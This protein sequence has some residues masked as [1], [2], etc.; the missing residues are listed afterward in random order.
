M[1]F[2]DIH[3]FQRSDDE[4]VETILAVLVAPDVEGLP[5]DG[6][7]SVAVHPK[8]VTE[9]VEE[10]LLFTRDLVH[11]KSVVAVGPT[12]VD[13][14]VPVAWSDQLR[15]FEDQLSIS[16]LLCKPLIIHCVRGHSDVITLH[17]DLSPIQPWVMHGF[18]KGGDTLNRVIDAELY[19][20][21]GASIMQEGS[22][23]SEAIKKVPIA[24][25][26]LETGEQTEHSIADIYAQAAKLRGVNIE[27]LCEAL[28][29]NFDSVFRT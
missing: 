12:G 1:I 11:E 22:Q 14:G 9:D 24:K 17:K 28:Q 27:E 10:E 8:H 3:S 26:L 5:D 23:A 2:K 13:R 25:L 29:L 6:P 16:E 18:E 4:N 19:V 7:C 21:F 20:S 15:A